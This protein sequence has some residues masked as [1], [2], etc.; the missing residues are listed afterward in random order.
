MSGNEQVVIW[1]LHDFGWFCSHIDESLSAVDIM[2]KFTHVYTEVFTCLCCAGRSAVCSFDYDA[3]WTIDHRSF[4]DTSDIQAYW[5]S[6]CP[7]LGE[8]FLGIGCVHYC[9]KSAGTG[10]LLAAQGH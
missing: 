4:G 8:A 7:R 1:R 10:S 3:P 2:S 6:A 5:H 9:I